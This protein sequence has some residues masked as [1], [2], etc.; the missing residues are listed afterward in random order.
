[1]RKLRGFVE[2]RTLFFGDNLDILG[3]RFPDNCID[4]IYLGKNETICDTCKKNIFLY[5]HKK[6]IM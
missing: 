5:G 6:R 4:L 1:M 3:D 2:N